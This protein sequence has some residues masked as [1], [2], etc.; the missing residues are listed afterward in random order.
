MG[1]RDVNNVNVIPNAGAIRRI[2][3]TAEHFDS[4]SAS[5]SIQNEWDQVCFWVM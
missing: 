4:H 5:G 2:L 3:V 1:V